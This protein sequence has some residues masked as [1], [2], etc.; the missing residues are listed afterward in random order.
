MGIGK[1]RRKRKGLH[2]Y[3]IMHNLLSACGNSKLWRQ[4]LGL[5]EYYEE[6][7]ENV[8]L[9]TAG[10]VC[11]RRFVGVTV[12][13]LDIKS[14]IEMMVKVRS[15]ESVLFSRYFVMYCVYVTSG[16]SLLIESTDSMIYCDG[17]QQASNSVLS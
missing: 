3:S 4:T 10:S 14:L 6:E 13:V 12:G 9:A 5:S 1:G 17:D 2:Y 16:P 15:I 7:G 8:I 11:R